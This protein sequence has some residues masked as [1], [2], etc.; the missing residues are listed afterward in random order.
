MARVFIFDVE[1]NGFLVPMT[2][3]HCIVVR[4]AETRETWRFRRRPAGTVQWVTRDPETGDLFG[5]EEH[6]EAEDT[7]EEG[8]R[9]L[10]EAD[11]IIGHNSIHFDVKAIRKIFPWFQPK[12]VKDTMVLTR[13][14]MS[15]VKERDFNRI[16]IGQH[17]RATGEATGLIPGE[18]PGK[19]LGKHTLDAWGYRIG[20]HKGTYSADMEEVGL[21]PWAN[22]NPAQED[23]CENDVDVTEVLWAAIQKDM[24]PPE[25]VELEHAVTDLTSVMEANGFPFDEAAAS[26]LA[27]KLK[28]D[29]GPLISQA[30]NAVGNWVAPAKKHVVGPLWDDPKGIN[31]RKAY[32]DPRPEFGEDRERPVWG[33]I[34]V[35]ERTANYKV[36]IH[37]DLRFPEHQDITLMLFWAPWCGLAKAYI[38]RVQTLAA[39]RAHVELIN[40]DEADSMLSLKCAVTGLPYTLGLV[41]GRPHSALYGAHGAE[42]VDAF[43]N[44]LQGADPFAVKPPK[45]FEIRALRTPGAPFCKVVV[46][47]FKPTSRQQIVDRFSVVYGVDP[48]DYTEKGNPKVD[49]DVLA[50]LGETIPLAKWCDEIFF[51]EKLLGY[52][53]TGTQ[54]WLRQF[55]KTTGSIHGHINTG[56][57][58][59]GRCSHL[60]PNV[61]QVPKVVEADVLMKDGSLNP[62]VL[63]P[64][65]DPLPECYKDGIGSAF[66]KK[67]VLKGRPG[68]YGWE[69]RSLFYMPPPFLQVGVDLSSIEFRCLAELCAEFDGGELIQVVLTGDIHQ[70]NKDK[71]GVE[72]RDIAKR[73]LYALMYGAG[74]YKLGIT[75]YPQ[76]AVHIDKARAAGAR[77]RSQLMEGLPALRKAIDRIVREARSGYIRG[78]DGRKVLVRSEHSVLNF[79]LQGDAALIAKRWAVL[80]EEYALDNGLKHGWLGDFVMVAFIHD[81][82]QNGAHEDFADLFATCAREAAAEAG[83]RFGFKCPVAAESKIGRTWAECH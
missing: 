22:W 30:V 3:M 45:Q 17:K 19:F 1:T 18:V 46:K 82:L 59:T 75:A 34:D 43:L 16:R 38:D 48:T 23:Y 83:R 62:L 49:H 2:T 80:T 58:P 76:L 55:D 28:S 7:L 73:C 6:F 12:D 69:C 81:E 63:G 4:D 41:G 77:I 78:L 47:A 11:T 65:G 40:V 61:A 70:H 66:K 24:P 25:C 5:H 60:V 57:T 33:D 39:G 14:I 37:P 26:A 35:P 54:S 71:S 50:A 79:K 10:M 29:V 36:P 21:N 51:I 31:R 52:V 67:I 72:T 74:D 8:V 9:M 15:D 32:D 42:G 13:V 64:D 27:Q 20:L 44:E 68:R 56:G 53:E